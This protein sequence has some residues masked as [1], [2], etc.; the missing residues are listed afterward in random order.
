MTLMVM[1]ARRST[2]LT[3]IWILP[4]KGSKVK[5]HVQ[6]VI[7]FF[8]HT[9]VKGVLLKRTKP[10]SCFGLLHFLL[11]HV[12]QRWNLWISQ[13]SILCLFRLTRDCLQL[14]KV[15]I[16]LKGWW[17]SLT[18]LVSGCGLCLRWCCETGSGLNR[19]HKESQ[20][21]LLCGRLGC[22]C[23]IYRVVFIVVCC[24]D[25]TWF[26]IFDSLW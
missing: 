5:L 10:T 2:C 26:F 24:L 21:Y 6:K 15:W 16:P 4:P 3:G 11:H 12:F 22:L 1:V 18:S 19:A 13:L 8:L 14:L 17:T 20:S 9:Q 7:M 23:F 25:W